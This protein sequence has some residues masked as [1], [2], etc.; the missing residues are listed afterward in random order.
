[1]PL[2]ELRRAEP[3]QRRVNPEPVVEGLYVLEEGKGRL[4]AAV[5]GAGVHA[6]GLYDAHERFGHG[7]VSRRRDGA[8][9]RP[10]A[11]FLHGLAEQQAHVLGAVDAL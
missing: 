5:V 2:L 7:V 11:G 9:E 3:T 6:L 8:H 10:Y 4:L 1:M